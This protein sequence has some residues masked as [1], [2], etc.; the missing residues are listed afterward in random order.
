MKVAVRYYTK[1]GNTEKL[2]L[3]IAKAVGVTAETTSVP[4]SEEVDVLFL[5]SRV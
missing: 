5:G 1:S 3:E 4:I 2:A